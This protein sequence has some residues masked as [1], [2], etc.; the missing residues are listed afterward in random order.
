MRV[1]TRETGR[2]RS[3]V[4]NQYYCLLEN[5]LTEKKLI[6]KTNINWIV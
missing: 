6:N 1:F 4:D 5:V 3:D 2:C